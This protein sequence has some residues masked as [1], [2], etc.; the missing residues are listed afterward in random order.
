MKTLPKKIIR[1]DDGAEFILNSKT[2]L[3]ELKLSNNKDP[4]FSY[5][6][7]CLMKTNQGYF[8][9]A[10]GTEDIKAMKEAWINNLR[11][12]TRDKIGCGDDGE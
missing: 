4:M 6:Y 11:K 8:K 3:Y 1:L 10:D 2:N 12:S 9:V 5:T 7:E